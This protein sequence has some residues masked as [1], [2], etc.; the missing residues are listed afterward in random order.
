VARDILQYYFDQK[1]ITTEQTIPDVGSLV[2][3]SPSATNTDTD[4]Q[5]GDNE[6]AES[7][8]AE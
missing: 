3:E 5:D 4:D 2:Y 7:Q 8:T 1:N 6:P